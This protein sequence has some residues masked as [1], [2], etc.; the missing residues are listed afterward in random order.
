V[1]H[2]TTRERQG[3]VPDSRYPA[4]GHG[5][6]CI[7]VLVAALVVVPALV[8]ATQRLDGAPTPSSIRLNRGFAAP[9]G[10]IRLA[11]LHDITAQSVARAG[12]SR[13]TGSA[14]VEA[15]DDC[16]PD[17]PP[18]RFPETRRGPPTAQLA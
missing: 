14:S 7:A 4:R 3:G 16:I 12:E 9:V 8:R 15:L 18:E 1:V 17:S 5:L 6:A 10:K 11:P 13:L 2:R